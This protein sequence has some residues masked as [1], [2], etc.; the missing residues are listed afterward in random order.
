MLKYLFGVNNSPP[1]IVQRFSVVRSVYSAIRLY[2]VSSGISVRRDPSFHYIVKVVRKVS[3]PCDQNCM[4]QSVL[5]S[6][7]SLVQPSWVSRGYERKVRTGGRI[8]GTAALASSD[9]QITQS[10]AV[11]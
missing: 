11:R 4:V 5:I 6:F 1:R 8:P 3:T 7:S 10:G 9:D 2:K